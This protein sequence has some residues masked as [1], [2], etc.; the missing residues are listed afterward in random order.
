MS[1]DTSLVEEYWHLLCHRSEV[2]RSGSFNRFETVIGDLVVFNDGA[3]VVAFDN[4][5][6]HRGARIYTETT[7][8]RPA[9]CAYHGWTYRAGRMFAAS[10]QRF[11]NCDRSDFLPRLYQVEWFEDFLFVSISPRIPL[12]VQIDGLQGRLQTIS[13]NIAKRRD[14][15]NYKYE[16]YWPIAVE[17]AL[18]P[19]HIDMIHPQTLGLLELEDGEN[20]YVGRN[21]VWTAPL[22]DQASDKKLRTLARMFDISGA[23]EGYEFIFMFPFTM[24]SSTYGYSYSLQNFFPSSDGKTSFYSRLYASKT[25]N[26]K[27]EAILESFFASTVA[28]NRKVFEEDHDVCR[29]VPAESWSM[30]PLRFAA[31]NEAKIQHFRESCREH[32]AFG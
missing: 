22:G 1:F 24:I 27:A 29:L 4:L 2:D 9:T 5:C 30:E 31:D 6:P 12:L 10:S 23:Y 17:N 3:T 7:G 8:R 28:I 26:K 13:A 11:A 15:S 21:S 20:H 18:E 32:V 14:H 16:C 19:Y 25:I